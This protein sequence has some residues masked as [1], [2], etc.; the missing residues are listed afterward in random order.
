MIAKPKKKARK[1]SEGGGGGGYT[2]TKAQ[3]VGAT[4]HDRG[5]YGLS[6]IDAPAIE[7]KPSGDK[8]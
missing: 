2:R 3:R 7:Y 4:E 6:D 1:T 5:P 8:L